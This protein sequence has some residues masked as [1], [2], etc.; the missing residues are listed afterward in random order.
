MV[1]SYSTFM[2]NTKNTILASIRFNLAD[3][4]ESTL[5]Y[6]DDRVLHIV[7]ELAGEGCGCGF[8]Y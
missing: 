1:K 8:W 6:N 5:A 2:R 7:E 3:F 4:I